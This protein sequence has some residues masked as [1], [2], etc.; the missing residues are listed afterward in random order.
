MYRHEKSNFFREIFL[1][2]IID[3]ILMIFMLSEQWPAIITGLTFAYNGTGLPNL[4]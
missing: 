2:Q 1:A 3:Q 4:C